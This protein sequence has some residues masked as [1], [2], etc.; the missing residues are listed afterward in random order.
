MDFYL[1]DFGAAGDGTALDTAALQA[2]IDAA[3]VN[4]G[5]VMVEGGTFK[6]G[7]IQ[8]RSNV[9]LHIAAGAVLLGSETPSDYQDFKELTHID[10]KLAPRRSNSCLIL[11]HECENA[12]ITGL[13]TI[14]CNGQH[15][16]LP[17]PENR[18]C[19]F[20]RIDGFTPPRVVLATGCRDLT[21]RDVTMVNQPAGWSYW[22][23]DC[24]RVTVEGITIRC[25]VE[26]PNNDGVHINCSRDVTVRDCD[27]CCSDDCLVVRANSATLQKNKP[28]QNILLTDC[29]LTSYSAG[30]RIG[31]V[32][33]GVIRDVTMRNM[34]MTDCS[35]GI[36]L[37]IPPLVRSEK[38]TDVGRESTLV[39]HFHFCD[40]DIEA[41]G[42][43][44]YIKVGD[45]EGVMVDRICDLEFRNVT[46]R[47][48]QL[49][50]ISGRADAIVQDVRFLDCRF[51]RTGSDW[52]EK[53]PCTGYLM[54]PG[55]SYAPLPMTIEHAENI[56]WINTVWH[57]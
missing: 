16:V 27:I 42:Y 2:A 15:F 29:R 7:S 41:A 8:M 18:I 22:I 50:Y 40:L 11:L 25:S 49:P 28:C 53:R 3:A 54:T 33:D 46:T 48:P 24:D 32:N 52:C 30:L 12:S 13:G 10:W 9:E 56:Q 26:Y 47:S 35:V 31:W 43:P 45:R 44:I 51:T 21:I 19:K 20:K 34:V 38:I 37:Y 1:Q 17:D 23:H 36:S 5:R 55:Q 6:I 57:S 39:E 4:G 14:D